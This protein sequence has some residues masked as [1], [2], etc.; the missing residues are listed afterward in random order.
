MGNKGTDVSDAVEDDGTA[1]DNA[2][3]SAPVDDP[4][5][6]LGIVGLILAVPLAVVGLAVSIVA[7][8]RSK[9]AGF[10]NTPAMIGVVVG[11]STTMIVIVGVIL[12]VSGLSLAGGCAG[13]TPGVHELDNGQTVS[14]Y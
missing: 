4:G 8:R 3:P 5:R 6:I 7:A 10:S 13:L 14:C 12:A 9:A 1:E 11:I 2:A